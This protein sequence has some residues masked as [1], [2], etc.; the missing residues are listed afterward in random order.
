MRLISPLKPLIA[1]MFVLAAATAGAVVTPST[2]VVFGPAVVEGQGDVASATF[3][4]SF[5]LETAQTLNTWTF[6]G[7]MINLGLANYSFA[8]VPFG[9]DS[10]D[11]LIVDVPSAYEEGVGWTFSDLNLA[12]GTGSY[13]A[14]LSFVSAVGSVSM[15]I[16]PTGT[17]PAFYTV[18]QAVAFPAGSYKYTSNLK[19]VSPVPEPESY[20]MLLAGLGLMGAIA[21]RRSRKAA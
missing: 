4:Q 14:S 15:T 20:A 17:A 7:S 13:I 10:G 5:G 8:V 11:S 12:L 18:N 21:R 1:A 6:F 19:T 3:W 9:S 16:D 2:N